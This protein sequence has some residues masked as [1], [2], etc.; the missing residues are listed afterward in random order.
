MTVEFLNQNLTIQL[1]L[2]HKRSTIKLI[3]I[4][5]HT[6]SSGGYVPFYHW[7]PGSVTE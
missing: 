2:S 4:T 5:K 7:G 3:V 6:C 1:E